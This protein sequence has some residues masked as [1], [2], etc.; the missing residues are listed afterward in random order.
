METNDWLEKPDFLKRQLTIAIHRGDNYC[1]NN[2]RAN[3][4]DN[5]GNRRVAIMLVGFAILLYA[6]Q[7]QTPKSNPEAVRQAVAIKSLT[8]SIR[9]NLPQTVVCNDVFL[10]IQNSRSLGD[11]G[12][13][14]LSAL[15]RMGGIENEATI[16]AFVPQ[17]LA[18]AHEE[19]DFFTKELPTA[20]RI[21]SIPK[22]FELSLAHETKN[23]QKSA[24]AKPT[25]KL[26]KNKSES[27]PAKSSKHSGHRSDATATITG[28]LKQSEI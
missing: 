10:D 26:G 4:I 27:S 3:D 15:L 22:F 5:N 8:S 17:F 9:K 20:G 25:R 12:Y 19:V 21:E 7:R 23:Q 11:V 1:T 2:L 14:R 13:D 24:P 16:A 28:A 18:W 6:L